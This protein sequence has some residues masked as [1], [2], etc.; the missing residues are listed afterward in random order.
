MSVASFRMGNRLGAG[1]SRLNYLADSVFLSLLAIIVLPVVT[2]LSMP[3]TA[4][5]EMVPVAPYAK[6]VAMG[7]G[8]SGGAEGVSAL[9]SNPA[10]MAGSLL[11]SVEG[12]FLYLGGVDTTPQGYNDASFHVAVVDSKT[13]KLAAGLGY[14]FLPGGDLGK[15]ELRVGLA[16]PLVETKLFFGV[17]GSYRFSDDISDKLSLDLG[18]MAALHPSFRLGLVSRNLVEAVDRGAERMLGL[19]FG[20]GQAGGI[21]DVEGDIMWVMD[22][23]NPLVFALGGEYVAGG[24]FP[25]RLG[26]RSE[27]GEHMVSGGIGVKVDVVDLGISYRQNL[28]I[29]ARRV[30]CVSLRFDL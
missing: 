10:G 24:A 18:L 12:S 23:D 14:S 25:V 16:Y 6:S 26:Y 5:A 17:G 11:Y 8:L 2:G 20:L 27:D 4:R 3:S 29:L 9:Y 19:G 30:V 1:L 7:D 28:S 15:H 13:Q 22:R 21:F